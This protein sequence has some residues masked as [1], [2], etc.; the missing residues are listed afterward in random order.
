M[1]TLTKHKESTQPPSD[2]LEIAEQCCINALRLPP[3]MRKS[4]F[5]REMLLP[6]Y[7]SERKREL[8]DVLTRLV[9]G[10]GLIDPWVQALI[11]L[12]FPDY[13]ALLVLDHYALLRGYSPIIRSMLRAQTDHL[14]PLVNT[15]PAAYKK[16]DTLGRLYCHLVLSSGDSRLLH[17]T[18][19]EYSH[20]STIPFQLVYQCFETLSSHDMLDQV[21][22][23]RAVNIAHIHEIHSHIFCQVTSEKKQPNIHLVESG[24]EQYSLPLTQSLEAR[25]QYFIGCIFNACLDIGAT[26]HNQQ[27]QKALYGA[28]ELVK[29]LPET[30]IF[31]HRLKKACNIYDCFS[32]KP[33]RYVSETANKVYQRLRYQHLQLVTS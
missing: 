20:T 2:S 19:G 21:L 24:P 5:I 9:P 4:H 28:L 30:S 29:S 6:V 27:D 18:L 8:V 33:L 17:T 16:A 14:W 1:T 22:H 3:E 32:K 23:H 13:A 10:Y 7:S 15:N 25:M 11:I 12:N 31:R 26:H